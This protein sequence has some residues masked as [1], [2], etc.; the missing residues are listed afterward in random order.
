MNSDSGLDKNVVSRLR[1]LLAE[2]IKKQVYLPKAIIIVPD[3]DLIN[4]IGNEEECTAYI[5]ARLLD[6]IMTEQDRLISA[7]KEKL[8]IKSKKS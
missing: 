4:F 2:A 6:N 1:N 3:E 8:P 7:Y 5:T